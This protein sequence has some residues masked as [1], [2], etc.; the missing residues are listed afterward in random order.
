MTTAR[1]GR[2][3]YECQTCGHRMTTPASI[4]ACQACGGP[5]KNIAVPQE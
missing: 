2:N 5:V 4:A 3:Y 1:T